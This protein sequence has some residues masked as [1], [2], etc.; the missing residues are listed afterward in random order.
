M[1]RE[2]ALDPAI[3]IV[4]SLCADVRFFGSALRAKG[5]PGCWISV[6]ARC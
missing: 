3:N 2:G 6:F 4:A 1:W 5:S